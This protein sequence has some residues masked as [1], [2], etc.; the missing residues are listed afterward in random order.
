MPSCLCGELFIN[1]AVF[2]ITFMFIF[3]VYGI[4]YCKA[5]LLIHCEI[6][7]HTLKDSPVPFFKAEA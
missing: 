3:H 1:C 4:I 2:P 5:P 7:W 6:D